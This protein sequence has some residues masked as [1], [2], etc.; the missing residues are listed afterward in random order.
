MIS[1]ELKAKLQVLRH[2][3]GIQIYPD[4]S[5]YAGVWHFDKQHGDGHLVFADGSEYKGN[6]NNGQF[7]GYG[8]FT[9]PKMTDDPNLQDQVGH[10]YIGSWKYGKMHGEGKFLHAQGHELF[11]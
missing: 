6:L 10:C 3:Y 1:E 7:D 2:G 11:P 4:K 8:K 9:W 5:R